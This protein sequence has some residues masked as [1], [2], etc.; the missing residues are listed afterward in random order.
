ML[1]LIKTQGPQSGTFMAREVIKLQIEPIC[2]KNLVL[3]QLERGRFSSLF[4]CSLVEGR[5]I[6]VGSSSLGA[7]MMDKRAAGL[8][9]EWITRAN[10]TKKDGSGET[11]AAVRPTCQTHFCLFKN[12]D[13]KTNIPCVCMYVYCVWRRIYMQTRSRRELLSIKQIKLSLVAKWL[14]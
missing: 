3:F 1:T 6:F 14:P 2:W 11:A 8:L 4:S 10:W 13:Q 12:R 9:P 5:H 7:M